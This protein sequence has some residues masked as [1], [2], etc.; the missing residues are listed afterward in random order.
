MLL[1]FVKTCLRAQ[2]PVTVLQMWP[3][4]FVFLINLGNTLKSRK[5]YGKGGKE[6]V[7]PGLGDLLVKVVCVNE[8]AASSDVAG[9]GARRT[10]RWL[11]VQGSAAFH[12]TLCFMFSSAV[13]V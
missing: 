11:C 13:F 8:T 4:L 9:T 3:T 6:N 5:G 7:S 10:R 2:R 1:T 12:F